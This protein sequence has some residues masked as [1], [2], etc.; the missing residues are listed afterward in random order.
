MVNHKAF[1]AGVHWM[2]V[3]T[4]PEKYQPAGTIIPNIGLNINTNV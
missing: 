3:T 2:V 4:H 1:D